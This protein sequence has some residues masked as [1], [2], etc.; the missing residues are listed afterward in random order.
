VEVVPEE[1]ARGNVEEELRAVGAECF[2]VG[3]EVFEGDSFGVGGDCTED[4]GHGAYK[5][6]AGDEAGVLGGVA[7]EEARDFAAAGGVAD[8]GGV[9][10]V[11]VHE[12]L[13]EVVG[14][15][16]HVIAGPGLAGAAVCLVLVSRR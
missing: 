8:H 13:E 6:G 14:V 11:E 10:E 7:A 9:G 1:R 4:G 16:V 2:A 3:F 15:G 5:D 12:E